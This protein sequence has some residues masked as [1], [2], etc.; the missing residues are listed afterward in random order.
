MAA[1]RHFNKTPQQQHRAGR[2]AFMSSS[3]PSTL[4]AWLV[5]VRK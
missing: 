1:S 2:K 5:L 4:F 3:D